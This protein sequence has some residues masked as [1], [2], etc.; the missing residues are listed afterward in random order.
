MA[1]TANTTTITVYLDEETQGR[2]REMA[3]AIGIS[4]NRLA[5]N[6]LI[7]GLDEAEF[8][9]AFVRLAAMVVE[10]KDKIR[11]KLSGA[12][13]GGETLEVWEKPEKNKTMTLYMGH[14]LLR[15]LNSMCAV[16]GVNRNRLIV[17]LLITGLEEA[18]ALRRIGIIKVAAF[19]R[20]LREKIR[21]RIIKATT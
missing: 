13:S 3:K 2:L 19:A 10:L 6:I 14:D 5:L 18:E 9:K 16:C 15:R 12:G 20:E 17:N 11:T 4:R 21:E 1:K 7:I 8:F